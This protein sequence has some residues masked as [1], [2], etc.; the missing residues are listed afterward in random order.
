VWGETI[1]LEIQMFRSGILDE[2][3]R[4]AEPILKLLARNQQDAS[5]L[6]LFLKDLRQPSRGTPGAG[7]AVTSLDNLKLH[8][9][10]LPP[11]Q[12][13]DK[14]VADY[15]QR[16]PGRTSDTIGADNNMRDDVV[17]RL[18]KNKLRPRGFYEDGGYF[19]P[20]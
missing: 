17:R 15:I 5:P 16:L 8:M 12:G 10:P 3:E 9:H 1:P 13:R 2:A 11:L 6:L 4:A 14:K 19:P 7:A 18:F 20:K